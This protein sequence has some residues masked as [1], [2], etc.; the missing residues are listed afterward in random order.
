LGE[1]LELIGHLISLA[2]RLLY[3]VIATPFVLVWPRSDKSIR[4]GRTVWSRYKKAL[5]TAAA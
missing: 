3:I 2:A 1:I 4:Y 5:S